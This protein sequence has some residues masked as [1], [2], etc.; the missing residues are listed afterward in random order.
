MK[1]GTQALGETHFTSIKKGTLFFQVL[2]KQGLL[3]D[4]LAVGSIPRRSKKKKNQSGVLMS[5]WGGVYQPHG[6]TVA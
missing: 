4:P 1:V 5:G 6:V 3:V 2:A